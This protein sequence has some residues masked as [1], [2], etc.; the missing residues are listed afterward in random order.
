MLLWVRKVI[1]SAPPHSHPRLEDAAVVRK[2]RTFEFWHDT[3]HRGLPATHTHLLIQYTGDKARVRG[4]PNI[5]LQ[6]GGIYAKI[7][8]VFV[9]SLARLPRF[10]ADW[11]P[12]PPRASLGCLPGLARD[13]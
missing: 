11:R 1:G 7:Q 5:T 6:Q 8:I 9:H 4:S 3:L 13:S 2:L 12:R 10:Q